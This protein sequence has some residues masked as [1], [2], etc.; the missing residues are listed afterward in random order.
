M[1]PRPRPPPHPPS[2]T[3]H[4]NP[5]RKL[6]YDIIFNISNQTLQQLIDSRAPR[7]GRVGK[8]RLSYPCSDGGS[9]WQSVPVHRRRTSRN[10]RLQPR[11]AS[12]P[13]SQALPP[14]S[15]SFP[16]ALE[17]WQ[18]P[19]LSIIDDPFDGIFRDTALPPSSLTLNRDWL[20]RSGSLIRA[21]PSATRRNDAALKDY[22]KSQR[23]PENSAVACR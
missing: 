4:G 14:T 3:V 7:L 21:P 18:S 17:S 13:I 10:H 12:N 6:I 8:R 19:L 22:G 1:T 23:T 16:L 11:Y 2:L 20:P 15:P 5:A 9:T